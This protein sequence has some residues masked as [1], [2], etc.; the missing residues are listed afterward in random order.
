MKKEDTVCPAVWDHLCI[1]TRG[2]NRLC[3]NAVTQGEDWYLSNFENHWYD[4]RETVKQQ[5]LMGERPEVCKECWKR[6]DIGIHSLRRSIIDKY[7]KSQRWEPFLENI[8]TPK[9]SPVELDL[10]IGNYCNLSCRMCNPFSSSKVQNENQRIYKDTGVKVSQTDWEFNYTQDKWFEDPKFI[11]NVK[12]YIDEGLLE[13]KFTGG[14]PLMVPMVKDILQYCIETDRAQYIQL[15]II[16]NGT[17]LNNEW[18][19]I[20]SNFKIAIISF[21]IDGIGGT[22]EYIRHPAVWNDTYNILKNTVNY[23]KGNIISNITF[24]LQIYN[25]LQVKNMINLAQELNVGIHCIP[26][27]DPD[28]LDVSNAPS[29]L[30]Q[31]AIKMLLDVKTHTSTQATFLSDV[32][33]K[34]KA[35][36]AKNRKDLISQIKLIS[37]IKDPYRDQNFKEQEI[38]K[39]YV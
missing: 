11:E 30:K 31:D 8:D 24:T 19:D 27:N 28:Y 3:C 7:K 39:Y 20:L 21:S 6:E 25:M 12:K 5:M 23:K 1:N 2:S 22:Y 36:P 32:L 38:Y 17:L 16:T 35:K 15:Q 29:S 4:F 18:L 9:T 34:I 37:T 13:L 10:K 26:L 33:K 14:E